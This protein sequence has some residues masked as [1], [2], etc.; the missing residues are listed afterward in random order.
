MDKKQLF[1][2]KQEVEDE[3]EQLEPA[4]E[5]VIP[6]PT[7]TNTLREQELLSLK[8]SNDLLIT[9][10]WLSQVDRILKFMDSTVF[11]KIICTSFVL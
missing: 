9:K 7:Y 4:K 11:E 1:N 5:E 8:V 10:E 3:A 6:K 2:T